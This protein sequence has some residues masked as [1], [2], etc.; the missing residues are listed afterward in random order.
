ME[1]SSCQLKFPGRESHEIQKRSKEMC[2]LISYSFRFPHK[3]LHVF[4]LS[5]A[6][7]F[8]FKINNCRFNG[9]ALVDR[10]IN[11][12]LEKQRKS[13]GKFLRQVYLE[14]KG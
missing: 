10:H 1:G 6:A 5:V 8:Y 14:I 3:T 2:I 12:S 9:R 7:Y 11:L 13:T 4:M